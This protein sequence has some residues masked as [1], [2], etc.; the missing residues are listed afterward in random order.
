AEAANGRLLSSLRGKPVLL[1]FGSADLPEW[2]AEA[3]KLRDAQGNWSKEGLELIIVDVD[4]APQDTIA[5]YNLLYGRLFYSHRDM[6]LPT[7]LLLDSRGDIAKI[8]QGAVPLER[9]P[10]DAREIP[11]TPAERMARGLPFPGM[12]ETYEVGRNY[13]SFGAVFYD[14]G[15][16]EQAEAYFLLAAKEDPGGCVPLFSVRRE[17]LVRGQ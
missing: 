9:V 17:W 3:A 11:K 5:V 15:Y 2:K 4:E 1:Y 14:R 16:F 12:S 7:A 8:Y 10:R 6:P 13:L